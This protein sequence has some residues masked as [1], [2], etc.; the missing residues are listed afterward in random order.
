MR[1]C[2]I[3][4]FSIAFIRYLPVLGWLPKYD[5]S[6]L[7]VDIVAGLTLWGLVV[8]QAMAYASIAGLPPQRLYQSTQHY[9]WL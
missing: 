3:R 6:W 9:R 7:T 4:A 8:S 2:I 1:T 5:R